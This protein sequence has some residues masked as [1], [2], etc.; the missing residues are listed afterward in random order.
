M[1]KYLLVKGTA[2]LGN[3]ILALVTAILYARMSDR[4]LAVDWR[5]SFYSG[6]GENIFFD[7]FEIKNLPFTQ[8]IPDTNSIYPS[9]WQGQIDAPLNQLMAADRN[10]AKAMG[11]AI[12]RKKYA[13]DV[14]DLSYR[15][16]IVIAAGYTEELDRMRS[17]FSEDISHFKTAPKRTIF[18]ET[19]HRHL[20]LKSN[21]QERIDAFKQQNFQNKQ[22]IGIHIRKSDRVVNYAWYK[23]ALADHVQRHP[24]AHI[25]L[26]TD[27]R[28]VENDIKKHY[29]NVSTLDK[30]LPTPGARAHANKDCPD[31]K[32]HAMEA[33]LDISLLASCDYL[34]YSRTT[35][36]GLLAS[37]ISKPP[38]SHFDIEIYSDRQKKS[39]LGKAKSL[40]DKIEKK[41]SYYAGLLKLKDFV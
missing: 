37:Y 33:L 30:W 29:P 11:Q 32:K 9:L 5:D 36:F 1:D 6:N 25:F 22:T 14:S 24:D 13:Y 4:I 15:E 40:K 17:V 3:R 20:S 10:L 23:Q 38:V 41:Y 35:S 28:D 26:A 19:F 39:F 31:P 16:D 8:S 7:L 18:R 34:I 12:F 27:N 21:L 2:G